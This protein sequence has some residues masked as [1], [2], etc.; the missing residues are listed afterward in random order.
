VHHRTYHLFFSSINH[1]EFYNSSDIF[2]K[3]MKRLEKKKLIDIK[4]IHDLFF[5]REEFK[6]I[7]LEFDKLLFFLILFY[8]TPLISLFVQNHF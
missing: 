8:L 6:Q 1:T 7:L 3:W 4:Y 5:Y 2:G